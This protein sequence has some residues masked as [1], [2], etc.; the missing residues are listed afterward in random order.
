[1]TTGGDGATGASANARGDNVEFDEL[2]D[3]YGSRF[4][5]GEDATTTACVLSPSLPLSLS[6]SSLSLFLSLPPLSLKSERLPSFGA[7]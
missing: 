3:Y 4:R 5:V 6:L 2:E 1:M 7:I